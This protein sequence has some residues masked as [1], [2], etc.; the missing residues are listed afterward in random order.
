MPR[1]RAKADGW[2]AAA[3]AAGGAAN[4]RRGAELAATVAAGGPAPPA[5]SPEAPPPA[6]GPLSPKALAARPRAFSRLRQ[7]SPSAVF[8]CE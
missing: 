1:D 8:V 6:R 7:G 5:V 4:D 3:K 2:L